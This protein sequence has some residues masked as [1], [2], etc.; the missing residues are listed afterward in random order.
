MSFI[1]FRISRR[2]LSIGRVG[3]ILRRKVSPPSVTNC[4]P[5]A[6]NWPRGHD[7]PDQPRGKLTCA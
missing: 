4:A 6:N 7:L 5:G 2:G 3:M 1:F